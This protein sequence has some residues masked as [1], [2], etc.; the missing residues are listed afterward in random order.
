MD[1]QDRA[2]IVTGGGRGIGRAI[3]LALAGEGARVAI[4]ARTSEQ[5]EAVLEELRSV[6]AEA[7]AMGVD[8]TDEGSVARLVGAALDRF[9]R[10]DILVNNAGVW[11]PGPLAD[12]S[13]ASWQMTMATNLQGVF[14]CS[15]AV[16][17]SMKEGG[18]GV[19]INVSSVR[20][21][22][23]YPGM[24]AY[25]ASKFGVNGLTEAL[26]REW[27]PFNI[28]VNAVCPGPVDTAFATGAPRDEERI[29]PEDVASLVVF[30]AS[31]GARHITGEA[32]LVEK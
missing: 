30:L 26:A 29:L 25:C 20:G 6:G 3:A 16:F 32:I 2:A 24:A 11:L 10:V 8:I 15:R 19:I 17:P 31:D 14:L 12:Y 28:R 5:L 22:E 13:L 4:G 18:G 9:G 1:L 23:G 27:R 7:M 21:R